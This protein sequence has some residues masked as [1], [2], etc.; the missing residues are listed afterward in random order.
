MVTANTYF[1]VLFDELSLVK[2]KDFAGRITEIR[3]QSLVGRLVLKAPIENGL[4]QTALDLS[5]IR[6]GSYVVSL[7]DANGAI[8]K[9]LPLLKND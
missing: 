1:S 7:V 5:G 8:L 4:T 2:T 6:G 9:T 3:I